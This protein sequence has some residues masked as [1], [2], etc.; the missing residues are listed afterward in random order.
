M[1][2]DKDNKKILERTI[3]RLS[4]RKKA[5]LAGYIILLVLYIVGSVTVSILAR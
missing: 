3:E 4:A 2:K 5:P 1:K